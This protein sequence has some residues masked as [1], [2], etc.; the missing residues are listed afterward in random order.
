MTESV[1]I[2]QF[3]GPEMLCRMIHT[4]IWALDIRQRG[5]AAKVI[6]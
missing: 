4:F 1:A 6:L 2:L 3:A 5:G